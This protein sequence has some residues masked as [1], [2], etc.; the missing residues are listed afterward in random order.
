[1]DTDLL[2][3]LIAKLNTIPLD[4]LKRLEQLHNSDFADIVDLLNNNNYVKTEDIDYDSVEEHLSEIDKEQ[5]V[6]DYLDNED[7][8]T[9][10]K[11]LIERCNEAELNDIKKKLNGINIETQTIFDQYKLDECMKL[12]NNLTL[13]QLEHITTVFTPNAY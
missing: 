2:I 11:K 12:Y 10:A 7:S 13:S 9:I 8:K 4:K 6:D 5:I 3:K 1:M